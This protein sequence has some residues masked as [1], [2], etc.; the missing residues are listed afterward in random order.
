M[1]Q[2]TIQ[3][4]ELQ[5]TVITTQ[6]SRSI[7]EETRLKL[8]RTILFLDRQIALAW[9]R[10]E[11]RKFKQ[12]VSTQLSETESN[13]DPA[14]WKYLPGKYNVAHDVSRGISARSLT[15][16]WQEAP[17]VQFLSLPE[18]ELP[19]VP[20]PTPNRIENCKRKFE[21]LQSMYR[22]KKDSTTPIDFTKFS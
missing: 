11:R 10:G 13:S 6:L 21:R 2:L 7:L 12:F 8:D 5:G 3:R 22:K 17:H 15:E 4:L 20:P 14:T 9:I 1:N 19:T 16:R 18:H